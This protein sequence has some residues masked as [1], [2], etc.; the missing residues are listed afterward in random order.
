MQLRG[1]RVYRARRQD[2]RGRSRAATGA[3]DDPAIA[4]YTSARSLLRALPPPRRR[5]TSSS[6]ST[7]S[8]TWRRAT[9]SPTT[10]A[11]S[12]TCR[13]SEPIGRSRVR[14]HH[15]RRAA[16][17]TST[18]RTSRGSSATVEERGDQRIFHF[19]ARRTSRRSSRRRCS[20]RGREVL[21]H[22]HVSTYKSW[23]DMG[24]GTGASCRTSSSPTT[25][26]AARRR[27]AD[28]GAQ[29]RP[30]EGARDLRLRRPEDALRGARV[31]HPRLQAVP[32]R[33]DLRARLRRLQRQGDAHR[34]DARTRSAS[35]RRSSSCGRRTR[36]TSRRPRR[37]WRRSITRSPTCRRSTSTSTAR[38][39]TRARPS[40][41]RWTAAPSRCRSTRGNPKLVRLP[42]PPATES[43]T[44][45]KVD[46]TLG[47]DGAAQ[48]DWRRGGQRGRGVR[49]ARA[50]PRRVDAQAARAADD[51]GAELARQRGRRRSTPATSRTS[52]KRV[53]LHVRGKVPQ[54]ARR[55]GD[56]L[57]VPVGPARAHGPRL[58]AALRAQARRAAV[59][60][61]DAARRLDGAAAAG[62]A[63]DERA[64]CRR[65]G[66][67]PFGSY[68][69][70]R[71]RPARRAST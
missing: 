45:H 34:D 13:S 56:T 31:R 60:A 68:D 44:S 37:A 19:V 8:R 29:G 70:E 2:R 47:A 17:S 39:N 43:V 7:A 50:L 6:S 11:R 26:C 28:E 32:V 10:S 27:G 25:R 69:V 16:R 51:L 49:V 59:R 1:A 67:S 20:R 30:R 21:G 57:S 15:A 33:A 5:A 62:R 53:T 71:R 4:T 63:G 36:A 52:S 64:R 24:R 41:R 18:S 38:R 58:R 3:A 12:T 35:R 46:A 9:R 65:T 48:V 22:V 14:A 61:E 66:T 42:D 54:F 23:D 40:S 55:E